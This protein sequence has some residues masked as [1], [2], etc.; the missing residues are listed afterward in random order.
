MSDVRWTRIMEDYDSIASV[1]YTSPLVEIS[2]CDGVSLEK[3]CM[4]LYGPPSTPYEGGKFKVE[5]RFGSRYPFEPPFVRFHTHIW[6]PNILPD[7]KLNPREMNI[8]LDL[9]NPDKIGTKTGWAPSKTLLTVIEALISMIA[10]SPEN[11]NA[12]II[13]PTDALNK[14]A[15][16]QMIENRQVFTRKA[17][18]MT[19]KYAVS[20]W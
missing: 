4:T 1:F 5:I 10:I 2:P 16:K 7:P 11:I 13:N 3:L 19:Q 8:C 15:A 18:E 20:G 9:I 6:H 17:Q 12:N 14:E